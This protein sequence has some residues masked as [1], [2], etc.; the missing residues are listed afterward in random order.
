MICFECVDDRSH[1]SGFLY[2]RPHFPVDMSFGDWLVHRIAHSLGTDAVSFL[3]LKV[4]ILD[5]EHEGGLVFWRWDPWNS[6]M[7]TLYR[8]GEKGLGK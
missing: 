4:G 2:D 3:A 5:A 6:I 8:R 7:R 1:P